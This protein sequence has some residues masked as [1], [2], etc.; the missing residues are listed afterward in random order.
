MSIKGK[1][2]TLRHSRYL[3]WLICLLNAADC[4]GAKFQSS[5]YNHIDLAHE[6][7]LRYSA[8]E[9]WLPT[10]NQADIIRR[11]TEPMMAVC[12][13][14]GRPILDRYVLEAVSGM[15]QWHSACLRC[16]ECRQL[17]DES[18]RTC[19]VRHHNVYCS[20]DFH[21]SYWIIAISSTLCKICLRSCSCLFSRLYGIMGVPLLPTSMWT[22]IHKM[23][24]I[25]FTKLLKTAYKRTI[26]PMWQTGG[27][28][29]R[30]TGD[31]IVRSVAFKV[32][33]HGA[34]RINGW[35]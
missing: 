13:G 16:V 21:R 3:V 24:W 4:R 2:K 10:W 14:C 32:D 29:D 6:R 27:R 17:I 5:T 7:S 31:S 26:A 30:R 15:L 19:F 18:S 35:S 34:V 22:D 23:M 25:D 28:T 33:L 20:A 8:W 9:N 1:L 11:G 12:V